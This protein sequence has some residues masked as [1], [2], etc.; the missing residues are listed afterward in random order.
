MS[1]IID[2][3][4]NAPPSGPSDCPYPESQDTVID[5]NLQKNERIVSLTMIAQRGFLLGFNLDTE[6]AY[7]VHV[8]HVAGF[9]TSV[10]PG[11]QLSYGFNSDSTYQVIVKLW[12]KKGR[13][14]M[15]GV[16]I[17]VVAPKGRMR[18]VPANQNMLEHH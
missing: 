10:E 14:A 9:V 1:L 18:P 11:D 3:R 5:I 2:C 8:S 12:S 15:Y 17:S 13:G 7:G 16:C 6:D 4:A